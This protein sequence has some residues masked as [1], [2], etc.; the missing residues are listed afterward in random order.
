ML[1]NMVYCVFI[2]E[3]DWV[4]M[5]SKAPLSIMVTAGE[6]SGEML[7]AELVKRIYQTYP[8]AEVFGMGGQ[9]MQRAGVTVEFDNSSLAII[10]FVEIFKILSRVRAAFKYIKKRMSSINRPD[11]LICFD[12]QA[13]NIRAAKIAYRHGVPV[14]FYAGPQVWASRP[15]RIK[16]YA[17]YVDHL[18]VLYPFEKALYTGYD[19]NVQYVGHP[20]LSKIKAVVDK[21]VA[22]SQLSLS[23][24]ELVVSLLPGSRK[25]EVKLLLPVL[26]EAA[27]LLRQQYPH[28]TLLFA[29]AETIEL[30]DMQTVLTQ[31]GVDFARIVENADS[32]ALSA[33][34]YSVVASGTAALEA[35]LLLKP[36]VV[37][38]KVSGITYA[39]AKKLLRTPFIS[40][41]NII[42]RKGIVKELIQHD[43]VANNIRQEMRKIIENHQYRA[44]MV[45]DLLTVRSQLRGEDTKICLDSW[46]LQILKVLPRLENTTV[47]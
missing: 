1:N 18:G 15:G 14:F 25:N 46:L 24:D 31:Y 16:K 41:P 22:R 12:Y 45:A 38:Y 43:C 42:S 34:D 44:Q 23:P 33:A 21:Q 7:C 5:Q 37:I 9:H 6:L 32:V 26:C 2:I 29:R 3:V 27:I 19:I 30:S 8:N 28:I 10:G 39:I 36:M 20:L 17:R 13:F 47:I 4:D 11:L 40:L 35:A